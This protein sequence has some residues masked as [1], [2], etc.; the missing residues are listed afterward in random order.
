M[1]MT[2]NYPP[3]LGY[4]MQVDHLQIE[5]FFQQEIETSESI[6]NTFKKIILVTKWSIW[7][8]HLI[9]ASFRLKP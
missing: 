1:A 5:Q 4:L 6:N 7:I 9:A 8:N 2:N 3:A